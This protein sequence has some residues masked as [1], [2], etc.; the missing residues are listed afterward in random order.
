MKEAMFYTS[1]PEGE[2]RCNLCNH[3]CKIKEGKRGI[4]GVRENRG[5][6]LYSLVYGKIV[7]EHIDPI[8]KKPLFHYYPGSQVLSIASPFCNFFC[9]FCDNWVISQQRATAA[10]QEMPPKVVVNT[11]KRFR[12]EGI[13][14]TYTEPTTFFEW[15]YDTAKLAQNNALFNTFVTNGYLTPEAVDIISYKRCLF[16]TPSFLRLCHIFSKNNTNYSKLFV[17]LV[18]LF[19]KMKSNKESLYVQVHNSLQR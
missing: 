6:K 17:R 4:C 1:L 7:A 18:I 2:I 19:Q 8:E 16:F 15:A 9:R 13:S 11:A 12:C 3:R 14:Y 10:T 5:G